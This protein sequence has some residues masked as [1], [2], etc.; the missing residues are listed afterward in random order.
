[1]TRTGD[2]HG[3]RSQVP[4]T[5]LN[6]FADEAVVRAFRDQVEVVGE[7]IGDCVAAA[8]LGW[9]AADPAEQKQLLLQ[10]HDARLDTGVSAL[11]EAALSR[12]TRLVAKRV[13]P[14][15]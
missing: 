2:R 5:K 11:V 13:K 10:L 12:Q 1:L 15:R 9:I 4:K 7:P 6:V 8:M 3:E 14:Q